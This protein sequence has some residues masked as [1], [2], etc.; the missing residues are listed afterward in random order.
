MNELTGKIDNLNIDYITGKAVLTLSIN[1][2]NSAINCYEELKDCEKVSVKIS[3]YREKRS[4][5]SNGYF[6]T[7]ADKLA[8]K[9]NITKEEVYRNAIK[10]IGGVSETVCVQNKAVYK[11][12]SGWKHNGLGWFTETFPS[13]L[14]G[15]TNVILYYGSSTY[16]TAQMSRLISNIVQDCEAVGIET[17]TPDE[18]AR[19][20]SMWEVKNG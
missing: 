6:W 16:D 15:C 4:L 11:L 5:D 18:L 3:K 17:K 19:M 10:N 20:L 9:M 13:K 7:L 8:E 12:C 1:E 14:E 2:K